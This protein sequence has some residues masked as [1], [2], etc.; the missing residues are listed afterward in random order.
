[1]LAKLGHKIL[2]L[3]GIVEHAGHLACQCGL[4]CVR[5]AGKHPHVRLAPRGLLNATTDV[6]TIHKWRKAVPEIN[7]GMTTDLLYV[8]D[9]DGPDGTAS[10]ERL[11]KVRRIPPT[12]RVSTGRYRGSHWYFVPQD[13][14][15]LRN[16]TAK[17]AKGL[18]VRA[19]GGYVGIAG[20][21][22]LSGY[23]YQWYCDWH[24][25]KRRPGKFPRHVVEGIVGGCNGK[26]GA[27][28]KEDWR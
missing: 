23:F 27:R 6:D 20:N 21:R 12:W 13:D 18:D 9:C 22:H 2:P 26:N 4:D 1:M 11:Q 5:N 28:T 7:F 16:S 10:I 24:P 19:V 14:M 25:S 8:L 17:V 15:P 3:W